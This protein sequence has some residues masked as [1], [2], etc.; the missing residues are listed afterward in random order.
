MLLIRWLLALGRR[1]H[2]NPPGT[3]KRINYRELEEGSK[4]EATS[5]AWLPN[6][7]NRAPEVSAVHLCFTS[8]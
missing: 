7:E 8:L 6:S 4:E 5:A 3:E 1:E 2:L